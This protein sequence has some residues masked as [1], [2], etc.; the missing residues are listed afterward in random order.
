MYPVLGKEQGRV[1]ASVKSIFSNGLAKVDRRN[2]I[3]VSDNVIARNDWPHFFYLN[4]VATKVQHARPA[5]CGHQVS[6]YRLYD[7]LGEV[8]RLMR[9]IV[10]DGAFDKADIRTMAQHKGI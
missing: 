6:D 4:V 9:A 10:A 3:I 2:A 1:D 7:G 8:E 5:A